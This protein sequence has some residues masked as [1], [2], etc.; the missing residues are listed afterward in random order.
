MLEEFINSVSEKLKKFDMENNEF[1]DFIFQSDYTLRCS[2]GFLMKEKNFK[3]EKLIEVMNSYIRNILSKRL[4]QSILLEN[5]ELINKSG[6]IDNNKFLEYAYEYI[7]SLSFPKSVN[8]KL[9]ENLN[10]RV[11]VFLIFY[12][13]WLNLEKKI[14]KELFY[15]K[16][17]LQFLTQ[18]EVQKLNINHEYHKFVK[19]FETE[20]IY[21]MMKLNQEIKGYST[22]DHISGVSFIA[23]NI[24]R[25]LKEIGLPIDVGNIVSAAIGH[26]IGKFGCRKNEEKRVPYLHYYY[27]DVWFK[28]RNMPYIANVAANHSTWDLEL[29]DLPAE[30]LVLIYADFR[31]KNKNSKMHIYNLDESFQVILDKL[32]NVDEKKEKR[33]RKVYAKLKD[34]ENFMIENNIDITFTPEG[35]K[36][37]VKRRQEPP[38][39]M[40]LLYGREI[41]ENFKFQAIEYNINILNKFSS[42]E[43]FN[44]MLVNISGEKNW[45][46]LREYM[47]TFEEY[48]MYTSQIQKLYIINVLKELLI[49]KE[50]DVR[51]QAAKL[52]GLLISDFD[53]EYRKEIPDDVSYN[54]S[55][56]S[57]ITL[58]EKYLDWFIYKDHKL[59]IKHKE[60]LEINTKNMVASV[61]YNGYKNI[62]QYYGVL[63]K[64]YKIIITGQHDFADATIST[65]A[66]LIKHIPVMKLKN[67]E[68]LI[69]FLKCIYDDKSQDI[70]VSAAKSM[71]V[72]LKNL[73]VNSSYYKDLSE[74]VIENTAE[75]ENKTVNFIKYKLIILIYEKNG[76][77]DINYSNILKLNQITKEDLSEIYLR[78]LKSATSWIEKKSNIDLIIEMTLSGKLS[79]NLQTVMHFCNLLKVSSTES[80]RNHSGKAMLS[81]FH[82]LE[83]QEKNEACIELIRALEMQDLQFTK[84]IPEYIGK[85]LIYQEPG[86]LDEILDDFYSKVKTA[87]VQVA[88]LM[89][90]AVGYAI[91]SYVSKGYNRDIN[92]E[93]YVKRLEKMVGILLVGLYSF[94]NYISH[95]SLKI[96]SAN[97]FSSKELTLEQKYKIYRLVDKKI[98]NT[99]KNKNENESLYLRNAASL[100]AIYRFISDYEFVHGDMARENHRQIAFFPGTFD[101]FSLGHKEIAKAIRDLGYDVYLAVDEFSWSKKTQPNNIR[102]KIIKVSVAEEPNIYTLSEDIQ[103]N[104]SNDSNLENLK[105][106]F[107]HENVNI[108]VGSDVLLN[109]SSYNEENKCKILD[110]DHIIFHRRNQ[111]QLSESIEK[112]KIK[113]KVALIKGNVEIL[114][115][116]PQYEDISSTQIRNSID[117]ERDISELIDPLAQKY[118]YRYGLYKKEP[119]FKSYF[120]SITLKTEIID[121]CTRA[122]IET[123]IDSCI[124]Q[125]NVPEIL[126]WDI[127]DKL[128]KYV[129]LRAVVVKDE[130]TDKILGF[131]TNSWL[132]STE[133][134]S[135]F[136]DKKISDYIRQK[137][138][139]RIAYINGMC[140]NE[141]ANINNLYQIILTETITTVLEKDYT[142]CIYKNAIPVINPRYEKIFELQG[143]EYVT[144][145][146]SENK[147]QCVNM[148]KPIVLNLDLRSMLKE[149]FRSNKNIKKEIY[150]T[151]ENLQSALTNLYKGELVLSFDRSVTYGKLIKKV[152]DINNV[153]YEVKHPRVLGKNMC[154]PYG[155]TLNGAL[156]PN[157]VT[158][159]LHT[160]KIFNSALSRFTIGEFPNY[161]SMQNQI[162]LLASFKRPVILIDDIL[163]KGHRIKTLDPMFRKEA[164]AVKQIVVA[165]LSGQG[166]E[167]MDMQG[168]EVEYIYFLPNLKNWFN[169]NALYPFMGGDYVYREGNREEYILSSINFI[170]PY[171]S[172][173]FVHDTDPKN[174]YILSEVCIKNAISIFETIEKEYQYLN[175]KS[176]NLKKVGEVFQKPRKPDYG[177]CV[178]FDLDLKPSEYLKND[179][180]KLKRLKNIIYR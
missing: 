115:L 89:L 141:Y 103:V 165:I 14:D 13:E 75:T 128:S 100:N 29:E 95:E 163:H 122:Q 127:I 144:G 113:E 45:K 178:E 87:N 38:K 111:N 61:F 138:I 55:E 124:E 10:K 39:D 79:N 176:F 174:L 173:S 78:N 117:E 66:Q 125:K 23:S 15:N 146:N 172:P 43:S 76:V 109:A 136:E 97:I 5:T 42:I 166:K 6:E 9:E 129:H 156:V 71:Y 65:L 134:Y 118:I 4:S 119:M 68:T 72:V 157:T 37:A 30:S 161:M 160:E 86:E 70:I 77:K 40:S 159:S 106:A 50:E 137:A 168:R 24:A 108:V 69:K 48:Y 67:P 82:L 154:V 11:I 104:L 41:A 180:E 20:Y 31:V 85:I 94:D 92:P 34:F 74:F 32:D 58:F 26:D 177:K 93:K 143:F 116:P 49:Y 135:E 16:Y 53:E 27:T 25:Q 179:L 2:L 18:T 57:G 112:E 59:T 7:L 56:T 152:C 164:I 84:Y 153:D 149:P 36:K 170:L 63:E 52:M 1:T 88:W 102:R 169:E 44:E 98:L 64:I 96:I 114:S 8:I 147:I 123:L 148:T 46:K 121:D 126:K 142:Y 120:S 105:K 139:G 35:I 130:R 22:L 51:N 60:W 131:T 132:R 12:K 101:P 99:L 21:E 107:K 17:S 80:V 171:A 145:D 167:L 33:Y 155:A 151:R 175:E 140:I 62:E 90:V 83:R 28:E 133:Y 158:K 150:K 47:S 81:I 162:K 19:K 3:A 73:N 54:M 91:E 110:F